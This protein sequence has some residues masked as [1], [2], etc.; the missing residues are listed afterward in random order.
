MPSK[1]LLS[2]TSSPMKISNAQS[3]KTSNTNENLRAQCVQNSNET[4]LALYQS[5]NQCSDTND[6][7]DI[8]LGESQAN[9]S[10]KSLE[11]NMKE[12]HIQMVDLES[13]S[14]LYNKLLID[15]TTNGS[16]IEYNS[17]TKIQI[18]TNIQL[19]QSSINKISSAVDGIHENENPLNSFKVIVINVQSI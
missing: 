18:P 16:V 3:F 19:N 9:N 1:S 5:K 11:E 4:G 15:K 13:V 7:L 17:K 2:S 14:N 6:E 10:V 12:D 8:S